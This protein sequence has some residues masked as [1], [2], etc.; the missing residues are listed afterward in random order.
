MAEMLSEN[1]SVDEFEY[2]ETAIAKKIPN[3]MNAIEKAMARH[4]AVYLLENIRKHLNLKYAS[5][6]VKCVSIKI[7]SG[8]RSYQLNQAVGGVNKPGNISQHCKAMACDIEATI[9]YK[10]G[11]R[12][13]IPY[14]ELYETI[15]TLTKQKKLYIDQCIQEAAYDKKKKT[16]SY[17]VHVS[18]PAQISECRYQFLKYKNGVYTLDCTLK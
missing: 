3:R 10:N 17:W 9:V 18:L 2:S 8:F 14:S 1:F 6:T 4:T 5:N 13:V 12:K 7:T 15:K 11:K 16:W